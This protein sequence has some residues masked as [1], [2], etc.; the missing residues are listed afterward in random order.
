MSVALRIVIVAL[1]AILGLWLSQLP[2]AVDLE[3]RK[4]AKDDWC[5][6]GASV[7]AYLPI[8]IAMGILWM[9]MERV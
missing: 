9:V 8:V 4:I 5:W 1:V 7:V 6:W 2:V 3:A